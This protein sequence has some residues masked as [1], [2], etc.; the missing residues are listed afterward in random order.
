MIL[1]VAVLLVAATVP[2]TG[3]N[4]ALLSELRL[5]AS[6][7]VLTA[8]GLQ[9]AITLGSIAHGVG[10]ALHLVSYASAGW[11]VLANRRVP[12]MLAIGIGGALNLAAIAAN[13][14]MMPASEW[15]L[16]VSGLQPATDHFVN[17]GAVASPRLWWLGDVFAIPAGWPLANVFSVGDIVLVG[18]IAILLHR[19][20]RRTDGSE[21]PSTTMPPTVDGR[22]HRAPS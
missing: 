15:A 1:P 16:R 19:T 22:G 8:I 3:G 20:C 13:G 9:L 10:S 2:L 12:G 4:L 11:F 21:D 14:G 6:W 18:G 17:S 7:A 5:R